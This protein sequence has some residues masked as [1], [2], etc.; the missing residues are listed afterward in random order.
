MPVTR[1]DIIDAIHA[2]AASH[3]TG[4][5]NVVIRVPAH[6]AEIHVAAGSSTLDGDVAWHS[7]TKPLVTA[8]VLYQV[9]QGALD[10]DDLVTEH[11]P[12]WTG[13]GG[14]AAIT[15]RHALAFCSGVSEGQRPWAVAS[16]Q[17]DYEARVAAL[18]DGVVGSLSGGEK[19][20]YDTDNQDVY[21][22]MARA[23]AGLATWDAVWD[24]W[25]SATGYFPTADQDGPIYSAARKTFAVPSDFAD[26][27]EDV[28]AQNV[29]GIPSALFE[30]YTQDQVAGTAQVLAGEPL[31][32]STTIGEDWHFALGW[33]LECRHSRFVC[34]GGS[35]PPYPR[36]TTF[37]L[38]GQYCSVDF[39]HG[40]VVVIG[41]TG[42]DTGAGESHGE[43]IYWWRDHIEGLVEAW[44]AQGCPS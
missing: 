30:E 32:I 20:V 1:G 39:D 7:T 3:H 4:D 34:S 19:H 11:I 44:I 43:T 15:L 24:A 35:A 31:D 25:R 16:D 38:E 12:G 27:L 2:A 10:L 29:N 26:F 17:A 14:Q 23:A 9:A 42:P 22:E 21:G 18:P 36:M 13:T 28:L 6:A 41:P 5:F 8:A 40:Y 37:G 33:W